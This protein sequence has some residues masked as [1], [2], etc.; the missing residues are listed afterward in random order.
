M[1]FFV[2]KFL[3]VPKFFF[4]LITFFVTILSLAIIFLQFIVR[5][6][7]S[8]VLIPIFLIFQLVQSSF[9]RSIFISQLFNFITFSI[10]TLLIFVF[11]VIHVFFYSTILVF[12]DFT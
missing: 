7:F 1:L 12:L 5:S 2:V 9:V 8:N 3:I 6:L 11:K 10:F 4:A